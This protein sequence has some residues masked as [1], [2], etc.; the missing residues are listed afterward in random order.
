M[1]VPNIN[2]SNDGVSGHMSSQ[3]EHDDNKMKSS[4]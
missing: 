3:G 1:V 4:L 2:Q